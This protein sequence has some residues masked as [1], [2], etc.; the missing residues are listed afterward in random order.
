MH[1]SASWFFSAAD[2]SNRSVS[3]KYTSACYHCCPSIQNTALV[4][5][6]SNLSI[7][8]STS[9]ISYFYQRVVV[10]LSLCS[11]LFIFWVFSILLRSLSWV[12]CSCFI[13]SD[14][15]YEWSVQSIINNRCPRKGWST[16]VSFVVSSAKT[17]MVLSVIW[18][19][20]VIRW[21][22][23]SMRVIRC[24]M[25][26]RRL[27]SLNGGFCRCWRLNILE[28]PNIWRSFTTSWSKRKSS[29]NLIIPSGKI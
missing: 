29:W 27:K 25:L 2:S 7:S 10:V 13:G 23:W 4:L 28:S 3:S 26:R 18:T 24:S 21:G 11:R 1:W 9:Y 6:W 15:Y 8:A 17:R 5:N 14:Y 22:W 16:F 20:R 12:H 19:P